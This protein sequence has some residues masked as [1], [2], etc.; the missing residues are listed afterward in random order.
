MTAPIQAQTDRFV[1]SRVE[2]SEPPA[3]A[4]LAVPTSL[5]FLSIKPSYL[6]AL[7]ALGYTESEARFL[8]VVATHSGYFYGASIP[9]FHLW[10]LGQAR[11]CLLAQAAH[12]ETR[13]HR[14]IPNEREGVPRLLSQAIPADRQRERAQSQR[15]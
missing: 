4:A 12:E 13:T 3:T 10:P 15:T 2:T 5:G 11:D 1:S 9:R 8:Y 14:I 6:E 7:E